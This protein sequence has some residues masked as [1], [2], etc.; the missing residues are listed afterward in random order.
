MIP[1]YLRKPNVPTDYIARPRLI[2]RLESAQPLT[3]IIAPAGY[4]KTSLV[5]ALI[6][7]RPHIWITLRPYADLWH[8]LTLTPEFAALR[9]LRDTSD[10]NLRL[11]LLTQAINTLD[12]PC[13]LVLEDY[14]E[15]NLTANHVLITQLIKHQPE[16]LRLIV[17]SRTEPPFLLASLRLTV[18]ITEIGVDALR[19]NAT[20]ALA[21]FKHRLTPEQLQPILT[22][23]EGKIMDLRLFA[24]TL[25]SGMN[26]DALMRPLTADREALMQAVFERQPPEI[27]TFLIQTSLVDQLSVPL[28]YALTGQTNAQQLLHNLLDQHLLTLVL[29]P[30]DQWFRY[31]ALFRDFLRAHLTNPAEFHQRASHWYATA[32]LITQAIDHALQADDL[33][34]AASWIEDH[35]DAIF[36]ESGIY[37]VLAWCQRF[38]ADF[39]RAR[40]PLTFVFAYGYATLGQ[41]AR[42]K[43]ELDLLA[44]DPTTQ[45]KVNA[46]RALI[47]HQQH[48]FKAAKTYAEAALD[49]LP[50]HE[51]R[52]LALVSTNL[53]AI[54]L[55]N[56]A[57][58]EAYQHLQTAYQLSRQIEHLGMILR[59]LG[60][61]LTI[62]LE[63]GRLRQAEAI[64][65]EM[66]QIARNFGQPDFPLLANACMGLAHI[67]LLRWELHDAARY[68][69]E[70]IRLAQPSA[71][72]PVEVSAL[73]LLARIRQAQANLK[74]GDNDLRP[75]PDLLGVDLQAQSVRY[76]L[77]ASPVNPNDSA[78]SIQVD[79]HAEIAYAQV[80]DLLTWAWIQITQQQA[81]EA[82][83][84]LA[85]IMRQAKR[86][87][88][89]QTE[90]EALILIALAEQALD[91]AVIARESLYQALELAQRERLML[92]FIEKGAAL[93]QLLHD[94][95]LPEYANTILQAIGH[96]PDDR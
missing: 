67:A 93:L 50:A 24:L 43:D 31:H 37:Q 14:H 59:A 87:G 45:G 51:L 78:E 57:L 10:L 74:A 61:I 60:P 40:P 91:Q 65:Q 28:A 23:T 77:T 85:P 52:L 79:L 19:F 34:T 16:K 3:L 64:A 6:A 27:Q 58:S 54:R 55:W 12:H 39:R 38:P 63:Q 36:K 42:A 95:Q 1:T 7:E 18:N 20:E 75:V 48:E 8:L 35:A 66:R 71:L 53:G 56:G 73:R 81:Q 62:H 15:S 29:D 69:E 26:P 84:V 2:A 76:A 82:L 13:T 44:D 80:F 94:D 70:A 5:A 41:V 72:I 46:I 86:F 21:L 25:N 47:A 92:P 32:G 30:L 4:G 68:A 22:H 17:L 33:T 96:I 89:I 11:G 49:Q 90:I 88:W 83:K 9:T